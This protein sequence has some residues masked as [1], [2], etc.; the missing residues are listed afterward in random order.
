L[1]ASMAVGTHYGVATAANVIAVK[2]WDHPEYARHSDVISA[3]EWVVR[4]YMES[5]RPSVV[6]LSWTAKLDVS[7]TKAAIQAMAVGLHFTG[8][9]GN[10]RQDAR[11][12]FPGVG[13]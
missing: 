12:R 6:N 4:A 2:V 13:K 7:L 5:G 9:A 1:V 3:F 10:E 11:F 8:A